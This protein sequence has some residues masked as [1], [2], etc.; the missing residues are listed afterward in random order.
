MYKGLNSLIKLDDCA[1][2]QDVK[3]HI[4]ELVR[5]AF[6][7]RHLNLSTI[8]IMQQLNSIYCQTIWQEYK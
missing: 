8:V 5:L 6:S 4:S 1:A 2:C 3:N 7:A